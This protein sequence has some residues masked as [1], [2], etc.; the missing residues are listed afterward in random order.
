M[1]YC[2]IYTPCPSRYI[3]R[4]TLHIYMACIYSW[5]IWHVYMACI[6]GMYIQ[7]K[8]YG[9]YGMYILVV[10]IAWYIIY[11][12]TKNII[13]KINS[14]MFTLLHDFFWFFCAKLTP[15][16]N[17]LPQPC[18]LPMP[19]KS[20]GRRGGQNPCVVYPLAF[21]MEIWWKWGDVPHTFDIHT[22]P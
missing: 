17:Q 16:L 18:D 3:L 13:K 15:K 6:W 14:C 19:V 12:Y 4:Y 21:L 2:G 11:D 22:L 10:Y 9:I 1:V 20:W 5:Y 8:P 7:C